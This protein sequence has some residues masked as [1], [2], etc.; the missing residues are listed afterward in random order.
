M[1]EP[2]ASFGGQN[3]IAATE[4]ILRVDGVS[5]GYGRFEVL[6]DVSLEVFP[7]EVVAII[8]PNG[9]GKSTVL[10]TVMGFLRP[11]AGQVFFDARMIINGMPTHQ[12]VRLGLGYVP[13]GRVVFPNMTVLEN[14]EL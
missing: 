6:H 2:A 10:K 8:G 1:A 5:A 12:L 9:A 4:P 13:Q 14:L 3:T 11:S 7:G